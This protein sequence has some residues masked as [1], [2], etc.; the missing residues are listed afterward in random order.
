VAPS[1]G[2][3]PPDDSDRNSNLWSSVRLAVWTVPLG[4]GGRL[5]DFLGAWHLAERVPR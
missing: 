2:K 5:C 1:G 3:G 4:G